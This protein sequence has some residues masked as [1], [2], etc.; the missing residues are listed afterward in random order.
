M[1]PGGVGTAEEILYLLGVLSDP[2]NQALRL[3]IVFTGPPESADYFAT[4]D[5]FLRLTLGPQIADRYRIV[6]GNAGEVGR[7][8]GKGVRSVRRQRRRDGDAYYFNWLLKVPI[9]HQRPFAVSHESVA[10]LRLSRDL[11]VH[12][13]AV[14]LRRAF[15]AIVTGNVKDDGIRMIA[16]HGP[17]ELHGDASLAR[18]LDDLLQEFAAQGRMKLHQDY[19][20]CYVVKSV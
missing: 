9:E 15:S 4:L 20:P 16:A 8:L 7:L 1:F 10:Q 2:A 11:P 5:E 18:A 14:N 19:Q 3:P 13:L 12:E 6:V 17:F